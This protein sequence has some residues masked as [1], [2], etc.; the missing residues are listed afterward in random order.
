MPP[1]SVPEWLTQARR[2]RIHTVIH[3]RAKRFWL[4]P[5]T[6]PSLLD[7]MRGMATAMA[8]AGAT[9]KDLIAILPLIGV[10]LDPYS[11]ALCVM[12]TDAP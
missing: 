4:D 7:Q 5:M 6:V 8:D 12:G 2:L 1:T 10:A 11:G 9:E 3:E